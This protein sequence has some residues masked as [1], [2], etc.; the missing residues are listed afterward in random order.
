MFRVKMIGEL[1]EEGRD[2]CVVVAAR[3]GRD[4]VQRIRVNFG[5]MGDV[6]VV[7]LHPVL[8]GTMTTWK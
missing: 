4:A 6:R 2:K 5:F 8:G 1:D 7:K 3:N